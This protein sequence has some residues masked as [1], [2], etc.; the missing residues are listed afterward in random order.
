MSFSYHLNTNLMQRNA[1]NLV[2]NLQQL[3]TSIYLYKQG[4]ERRVNG[5]SIIGILSGHFIQGETIK[6]FIDN[7]EQ[8]SRVKEIFN[9][10]G[11]EV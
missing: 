3:K 9:N 11:D 2:F 4:L 8:L 10:Y 5:K 6:I 7:P 1:T